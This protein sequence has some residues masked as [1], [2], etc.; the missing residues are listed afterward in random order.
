MKFFKTFL[1][2]LVIYLGLNAL[3]M[4]AAIFLVPGYPGTDAL[5]LLAAVF[6]PISIAPSTAWIGSGIVGLINAGDIVVVL[7]VFLG[8]IIPPLIS[9]I[10][11]AKIGETNQTGFGAWF[12]VALLSCGI[13]AII[14]GIG[15][16]IPIAGAN[17]YLDWVALITVYGDLGA[18]LAI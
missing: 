13:Y 10:V 9:I 17:L 15:Q 6:S 3:F 8:L 2:S 16:T 12:T 11:A 18:I 5:Y 14:L 4:L 1:V 7:M